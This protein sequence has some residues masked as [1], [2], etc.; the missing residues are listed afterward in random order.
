M[1]EAFEIV[2]TGGGARHRVFH[3][4]GTL[5]ASGASAL[6]EHA[7]P[8]LESALN[9][10]LNLAQVTF[11]SSSGIGALV[12]LSED[13]RERGLDLRL[14]APSREVVAPIELLCL[15][16]FLRICDSDERAS[17]EWVA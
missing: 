2:E 17:A 14:S 4:V 16:R 10:V 9:L 5:D 3:L 12:A 13:F 7:N 15:D 6:T 1:T 11:V 8:V